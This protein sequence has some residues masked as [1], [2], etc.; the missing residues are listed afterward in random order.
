MFRQR[1]TV[2]GL[3]R[4]VRLAIDPK[5]DEGLFREDGDEGKADR[6]F[7]AASR[8]HGARIVE[9]F[10]T[11]RAPAAVY[12]DPTGGGPRP[13]AGERPWR[14]EDGAEVLH[15]RFRAFLQGRYGSTPALREAWGENVGLDT[16]RLSPVR[17]QDPQKRADW[18][19]FLQKGLGFPYATVGGEADQVAYQRFLTRRYR[20]VERLAKQYQ[21]PIDS[22]EEVKLP[23]ED[24]FPK[25][26]PRLEDW[27]DFVSVVLP[28]RRRAH[29]FT[30]LVPIDPGTAPAEQRRRVD[31][32][33]RVVAAEKPAHTDFDVR[34]YWAAFQVGTARVGLDTRIEQG[35]R[36][37]AVVLGESVLAEGHVAAAHPWNVADR[38]VTGRDAAGPETT[39]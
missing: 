35:S 5:A 4:A 28:T 6:S 2:R 12:G 33:R 14:P 36:Y 37:T 34:P 18:E 38:M 30:V 25:Q 13:P 8:S 7:G 39:L 1:G 19:A 3:A 22:F 31:L 20:R 29:R 10:L 9:R 26:N 16:A 32:A 21:R 23:D 24:D 11:R 17:P 15:Q 27:I